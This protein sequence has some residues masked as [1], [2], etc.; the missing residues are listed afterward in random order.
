MDGRVEQTYIPNTAEWQRCMQMYGESATGSERWREGGGGRERR[1]V[2][3]SGLS[4]IPGT[5][6]QCAAP[7][8]RPRLYNML[9]RE[10]TTGG[11][12]EDRESEGK[13]DEV[14]GCRWIAGKGG[15]NGRGDSVQLSLGLLSVPHARTQNHS[16]PVTVS[17][18]VMT[19]VRP[20]SYEP[21]L[22]VQ[23]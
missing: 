23:R 19:Q 22:K 7:R 15:W 6:T 14:E 4:A 9:L 1:L 20:V 12:G 11:E 18:K 13:C 8:E 10:E 21:P 2:N 3:G 16:P 17:V 5:C